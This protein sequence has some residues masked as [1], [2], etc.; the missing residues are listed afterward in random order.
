MR[1]D[2]IAIIHSGRAS[3]GGEP[4]LGAGNLS[5]GRLV[6]LPPME[7]ASE[8]APELGD[9]LIAAKG[10]A[11]RVAWVREPVRAGVGPNLIIVRTKPELSGPLYAILSSRRYLDFLVGLSRGRATVFSLS[12][13]D[14]AQ[15]EIPDLLNTAAYAQ[16]VE[17]AEAGY[18]AALESA[19]ARRNLALDLVRQDLLSDMKG[20]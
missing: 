1:L 11:P 5:D 6:D 3:K 12:A 13:K 14:L 17:L 15:L 9:I 20:C 2:E 8:H 19:H 16:L 7:A 18:D 10:V 4:V